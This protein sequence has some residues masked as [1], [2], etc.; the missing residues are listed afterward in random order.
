MEIRETILRTVTNIFSEDDSAMF[1][2]G[3]VASGEY[4][5]K[6]SDVDLM[7]VVK[8][9][10]TLEA[11]TEI[12]RDTK[13]KLE[14]FEN[15]IKIYEH[16]PQNVWRK[17]C[18]IIF[19]EEFY[20]YLSIFPVR[21]WKPLS[22]KLWKLLRALSKAVW[23]T[24]GEKPKRSDALLLASKHYKCD[25]LE[26]LLEQ[27]TKLQNSAFYEQEDLIDIIADNKYIF[28]GFNYL[29]EIKKN[30]I[31]NEKDLFSLP[32]IRWIKITQDICL[33][34][35]SMRMLYTSGLFEKEKDIS[36]KY[37][38]WISGDLKLLTRINEYLEDNVLSSIN[39]I[40]LEGKIEQCLAVVI[41]ERDKFLSELLKIVYN[42]KPF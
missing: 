37:R 11:Y 35:R 14:I 36:R 18:E 2:I 31:V 34:I 24:T 15:E 5:E 20:E 4:H 25:V 21:V 12:F 13:E 17:D 22:L 26:Y 28:E 7:Y 9:P 16:N 32:I 19:Q 39:S 40:Y 6:I 1:V 41:Y 29:C 10:N 30:M 42:K 23:L 3:S 33:Q 8:R 38:T 27:T